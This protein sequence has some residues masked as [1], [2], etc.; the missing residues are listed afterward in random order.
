MKNRELIIRILICTD[1]VRLILA[2]QQHLRPKD[3]SSCENVKSYIIDSQIEQQQYKI[4]KKEK[5]EE[6]K[7]REKERKTKK[8]GVARGRDEF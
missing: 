8:D 5:D 1:K 6:I 7:K 4:S 2:Q 3:V